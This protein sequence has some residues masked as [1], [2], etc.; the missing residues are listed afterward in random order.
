[1]ADGVEAPEA[2][3]PEEPELEPELEPAGAESPPLDEPVDEVAD[4][5]VDEPVDEVAEVQVED[6]AVVPV[7]TVVAEEDPATE[8]PETPELTDVVDEPAPA[9]KKAASPAQAAAVGPLVGRHH[10][11]RQAR[12]TRSAPRDSPVHGARQ[13]L[14]TCG[15]VAADDLAL[16]SSP[17]SQSWCPAHVM[18][19]CHVA[20]HVASH[21]RNCCHHHHGCDMTCDMT[22][23]SDNRSPRLRPIRRRCR[24]RA[25]HVESFPGGSRDRGGAETPRRQR[26]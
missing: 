26:D 4:E 12:L 10:V 21:V 17:R 15:L 3:E 23:W 5:P 18:S 2:A 22:S 13:Q 9:A 8:T 25:D 7:E 1:M 6:V 19:R 11:R 16:Q 14:S 24:R 20:S